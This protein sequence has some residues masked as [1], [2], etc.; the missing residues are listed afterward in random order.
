MTPDQ[1]V[2]M[3]PTWTIMLLTN[4]WYS[5]VQT[6]Y[7]IYIYQYSNQYPINVRNT[8]QATC[9]TFL[10]NI[11]CKQAAVG[12]GLQIL[13]TH[14]SLHSMLARFGAIKALCRCVNSQASK[15]VSLLKVTKILKKLSVLMLCVPVFIFTSGSS[16]LLGCPRCGLSIWLSLL[17]IFNTVFWVYANL[18][19]EKTGKSQKY[20]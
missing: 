2:E 19:H 1:A 20:S 9:I 7:H 17:A 18:F 8:L 15:H 5:W 14:P 3:S 11:L 4:N 10:S 16:A 6:I 12:E 13:S